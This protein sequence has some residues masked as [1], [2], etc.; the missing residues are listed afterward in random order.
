M[1]G[2]DLDVVGLAAVGERLGEGRAGGIHR[3]EPMVKAAIGMRP[4]V[5]PIVTTEPLDSR[6]QRPGSAREPHMGE[7]FER[8]ALRQSASVRARKSP[9]LVVPALLTRM[10]SRP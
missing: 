6:K 4:L 5:P 7:E 1:D 3:V 10:S 2:V 8:V 9:R